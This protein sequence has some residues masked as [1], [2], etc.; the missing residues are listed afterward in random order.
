MDDYFVG[1]EQGHPISREQLIA[2][3]P[4]LAE[5]LGETLESLDFLQ[6]AAAGL[7]A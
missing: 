6:Q 2:R 3:H 1:L 4:D 5:P 7:R